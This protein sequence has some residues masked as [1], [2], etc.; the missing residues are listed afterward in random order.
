MTPNGYTP[1]KTRSFTARCIRSVHPSLH[2]TLYSLAERRLF[3]APTPR[4][5]PPPARQRLPQIAFRVPR[6]FSELTPRSLRPALPSY[7]GEMAS[8]QWC[9]RPGRPP[10]PTRAPGGGVARP[11]LR[12]DRRRHCIGRRRSSATP[13]SALRC[14]DTLLRATI[15]DGSQR[16]AQ[17]SPMSH[18]LDEGDSVERR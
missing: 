3:G 10:A 9:V 2:R 5:T 16:P 12:G 17:S 13:S 4:G 7:H 11:F 18:A 8:R 6:R 14:A 15:S 1:M